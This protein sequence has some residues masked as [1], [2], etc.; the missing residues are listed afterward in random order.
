MTSAPPSP[1]LTVIEDH[2]LDHYTLHD[3]VPRSNVTGGVPRTTEPK[4]DEAVSTTRIVDEYAIEKGQPGEKIVAGPVPHANMDP[5]AKTGKEHMLLE[6]SIPD[7]Y[8]ALEKE[9]VYLTHRDE[10]GNYLVKSTTSDNQN[11][12]NWANW[13]RY[14]VVALASWLNILV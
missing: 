6:S 9:H 2:H 13:K 12:R 14:G 11:P 4:S 8:R 7:L 1:D 5:E 10:E 3:A